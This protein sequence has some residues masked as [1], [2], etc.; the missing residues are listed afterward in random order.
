M[1]V[2][3]IGN[4]NLVAQLDEL[5]QPWN[6]SD[7]PGLAVGIARGGNVVYRR[8]FGMASLESRVAITPRT[9]MRIASVS[10][11]FTSLLALL[12]A[13]DGKLE[14]DVPIRKYIP[15]LVGS[16]GEPTARQLLQHRGGSRCHLDL[17]FIAHGIATP[18]KGTALEILAR[19]K[20]RNFAPG[21][22]MI[23]N[24]G[25]YHLVSIAIERVGGSSFA[26]QL[27]H[28]LFDPLNMA[29]TALVQSDYEITPG[30]ATMHMPIPDTNGGWRR[31]LFCSEENLGEGGIVS[32]VDDMLLWATHLRCRDTFGSSA[33]WASLTERPRYSDGSLGAYALGL[34]LAEYRGLPT[35]Q[36]SGS[37]FGGSS[38]FITFPSHELDIVVLINGGRDAR[39]VKL[40]NLVAD[41][42][43]SDAV[44][45]KAC[46]ISAKDYPDLI[47]DWWSETTQ[48]VY[49]LNNEDGA[50][51][52]SFGGPP[53][54]VP[55][56]RLGD[57][58]S[59]V[60]ASG[61]GEIQFD[62]NSV[63]GGELDIRFAGER[64]IYR[65]ADRKPSD[66]AAFAHA[67]IGTYYSEDADCTAIIS[68]DANGLQLSVRDKH[69]HF[70][71]T[72]DPLNNSAAISRP[73]SSHDFLAPIIALDRCADR[74]RGFY[75][76]TGRTRKL[77]FVRI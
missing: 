23:Y 58:R 53:P 50:L 62:I 69:G 52:M 75:V 68:Q 44:G 3:Q 66:A 63:N 41:L 24:N 12:L 6:R 33:T 11:H 76:N 19:Q 16:S 67:A 51:T 43:L 40:G 4:D 27:K 38:Q 9:R 20:G 77:A 60:P 8:G 13:E 57:G 14:L 1:S 21:E 56:E 35:I 10:K 54:G 30:I 47:G 45:P 36:H 15:E 72:L 17:G 48:M 59:V 5:F 70:D 2:V 34:M 29:D 22:G 31:G 42:I 18:P 7:A 49:T 26:D 25:G 39:A 64:A 28:R 55:L 37:V 46:I 71:A 74:A 65:K 32:T 61:I 73:I